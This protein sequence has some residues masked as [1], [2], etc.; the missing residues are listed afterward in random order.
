[1]WSMWP[2]IIK[3][4][5]GDVE[6]YNL[7][8]AAAGNSYIAHQIYL[9]DIKYNFGPDDLIMVCWTHAY[10]MDWL[11]SDKDDWRLEGFMFYE[12]EINKYISDEAKSLENCEFRDS[13]IIACA[14]EYLNNLSSHTITFSWID[15][16]STDQERLQPFKKYMSDIPIW[17]TEYYQK[18]REKLWREYI[19]LPANLWEEDYDEEV[20]DTHPMPIETL[21][22]LSEALEYEFRLEKAKQEAE[23]QRIDA[24]GKATANRILSAS[25]TD[26]IL[27]D[28]GIEAT[29]KLAESPNSKVV[30]IGSGESG[31][32]I[33][34]GNQ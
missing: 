28:K 8:R 19:G 27:Q 3:Q 21:E 23:R 13:N 25:L 30:I 4:E 20:W 15:N 32:P 9:A 34:L 22:F 7:G 26:K 16:L 5:L 10:R 1:M 29:N 17:N 12:G 18:K 33:I 2:E 6:F 24:E 31:M 14:T 11:L